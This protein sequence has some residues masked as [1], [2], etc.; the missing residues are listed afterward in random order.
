MLN[1]RTYSYQNDIWSLGISMY[2][3]AS[4]K[5][6]YKGNSMK[7]LAENQRRSKI[8]SIPNHYSDDLKLVVDTLLEYDSKYRPKTR[9]ILEMGV[10]Q[11][12]ISKLF[13]HDL[14]K[15]EFYG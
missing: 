9:E 7:E 10:V 1:N 8:K 4:L 12:M 15:T 11:R 14:D 6:P 5:L 3:L 13:E 2:Q